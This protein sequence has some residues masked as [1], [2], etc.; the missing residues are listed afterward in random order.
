MSPDTDSLP[1]HWQAV[2][3]NLSLDTEQTRFLGVHCHVCELQLV[4]DRLV[5]VRRLACLLH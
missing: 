1:V 3:I 2:V 4:L 5:E